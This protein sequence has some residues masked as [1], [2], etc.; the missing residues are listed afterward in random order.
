MVKLMVDLRLG[1]NVQL[2]MIIFEKH[3]LQRID[4]RFAGR[5]IDILVAGGQ[6]RRAL[7]YIQQKLIEEESLTWARVCWP[8]I[9]TIRN[10][11]ELT[12]FDWR[13]SDGVRALRQRVNELRPKLFCYLV[14]QQKA[15]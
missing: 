4:I 8:K 9:Q 5:W 10:R 12:H 2:L 15:S 11:L 3:N 6:E 1:S 14:A 7:R 13:E